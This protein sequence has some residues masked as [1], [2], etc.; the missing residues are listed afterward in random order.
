MQLFV[1][2]S[3]PPEARDTLSGFEVFESSV[4]E[5]MLGRIQALMCW[6]SRVKVDAL[7]K[8]DALRMVQ[9]LSAGVDGLDFRALPPGV[10][11]FS[12]A[13]AFTE[14]VGEHA[15]GL[16]LG[17]AKGVHLRNQK[18]TPRML[19]GKTLVVVGCG[20]I[21]SEAARLSKSVGMRTVGVSRSFR[22]PELFE[23]KHPMSSLPELM[24]LA[25]AVVV[26]IPLTNRTRGAFS[27]ELLSRAKDAVIVVNIGRGET[28]DEDGTMRWLKERPESRFAT[29]VFWQKDG[30]EQF[31]TPAWELPNFGGTLHDSGLPLGEDL[32][33]VKVAAARNV[34]SY[35]ENGSAPNRV[36]ASEYL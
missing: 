5:S 17:M 25:D 6:P 8:M 24:P 26:T 29:D 18:A 20:A 14:P 9:T 21:G 10:Q 33:K 36:D 7:R 28:F 34:R 27:Y 11:V 13:G 19:R 35:F 3:L 2:D 12:N 32:S 22:S 4:D 23:E 30:K 31:S 15:W 1:N 16:L